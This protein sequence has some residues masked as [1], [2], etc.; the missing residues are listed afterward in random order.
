LAL[1]SFVAEA[2]LVPTA[3]TGAVLATAATVVV[4]PI[5]G[6]VDFFAAGKG[7]ICADEPQRSFADIALKRS[8]INL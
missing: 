4:A 2:V 1:G 3:I 6:A 5:A 7:C 8:Q